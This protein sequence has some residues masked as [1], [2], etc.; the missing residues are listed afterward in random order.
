LSRPAVIQKFPLIKCC[1]DRHSSRRIGGQSAASVSKYSNC[2]RRVNVR[3]SKTAFVMSIRLEKIVKLLRPPSHVPATSEPGQMFANHPLAYDRFQCR[4]GI[5]D[6]H[7]N[8]GPDTES[9]AS[10]QFQNREGAAR[11]RAVHIIL[12]LLCGEKN[13]HNWAS[14]ITARAVTVP[15]GY[16]RTYPHPEIFGNLVPSLP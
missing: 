8:E 14:G 4:F 1:A 13:R 16:R 10:D 2:L 7:A 6:W 12:S 11:H 15:P 3:Y 5:S 9:A